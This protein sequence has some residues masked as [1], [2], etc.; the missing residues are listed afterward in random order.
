ML[1]DRF[2]QN[3]RRYLGSDVQYFAAVEPW[4]R[5]APHIHIAMRGTV[6]HAKLRRVLATTYQQVWWPAAYAVKFEDGELPSTGPRF[7]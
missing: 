6:S 2:I 5:L 7:P 1:F 3:L 4:R